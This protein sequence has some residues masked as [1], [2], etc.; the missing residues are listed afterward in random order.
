MTAQKTSN[1]TAARHARKALHPTGLDATRLLM[2]QMIGGK[3][4]T[5]TLSAAASIGIPAA[6]EHEGKTTKELALFFDANTEKLQRV[7]SALCSLNVLQ[8]DAQSRYHL[9][10]LGRTLLP[11][12]LG[13]LAQY[14][15][16]SF[17]WG[18]WA[19]LDRA[20]RSD[21]SAF[22]LH[23]GQALYPYLAENEEDAY[24]YDHG[25]DAF[26]QEEAS[27]LVEALNINGDKTVLDLG[28][29]QGSLLIE[30]L[31]EAPSLNGILFDLPEVVERAATRTEFDDL[32][33][34]V[35]F[36]GG[37]F[38]KGIPVQADLVLLKRVL[39]NWDDEDA[40]VILRNARTALR[41]DDAR[42]VVIEAVLL[43]ENFPD[44]GRLMDLEMMV[45]CDDG[46]ERTKPTLRR[47]LAET[48]FRLK[49]GGGLPGGARW[50]VAAPRD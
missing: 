31:R 42:I 34:R 30:M 44:L 25:V 21:K 43:P 9:T 37:D 13:E 14:A 7:L 28:G 26:T 19:E 23:H 5:A 24:H 3:W 8:S 1:E 15:G 17:A 41:D 49:G 46:K 6:L 48:G 33:A 20:I 16:R 50:L 22:Q 38:M 36:Q 35:A 40:K 4:V 12:Q 11:G 39:H 45:M 29:G 10:P 47:L 2:L 18:P 27:A 32:R